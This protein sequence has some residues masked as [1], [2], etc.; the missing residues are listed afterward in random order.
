M[1]DNH[2]YSFLHSIEHLLQVVAEHAMVSKTHDPC[3]SYSMWKKTDIIQIIIQVNITANF[4]KQFEEEL[5]AMTDTCLG[6]ESQG[7]LPC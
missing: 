5:G 2:F 4:S 7:R 6:W 1:I 3:L